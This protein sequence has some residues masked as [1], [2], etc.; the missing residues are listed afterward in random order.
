MV[1][2]V[3]SF[4]EKAKE[5]H[6][7]KYDYSKVNY[8]NSYT[9]VCIICHEKDEN[10][11]EHGEFWQTPANHLQGTGCKK[12]KREKQC[13]T[14]SEIQE[15][16]NEIYG[17]IYTVNKRDKK[18]VYFTCEKHGEQIKKLYPFLQGVGC[19]EC[20]MEKIKEK[21]RDTLDE[22]IEKAKKIHGDKYDYSKVLYDGSKTNVCIICPEHGEFY[23][24]PNSLLSGQG[25]PKCGKKSTAKKLSL[26]KEQFIKKAREIHGW[27]YDYSKVEYINYS[28]EVCIICPEHGEF[29]QTPRKHLSGHECPFCNQSK[30][31]K[32]IKMFLDENNVIYETEKKF[33][34]SNKKRYDFYL[35]NYNIL[36]EC[37]GKQHFEPN[38][39]F[40]GDIGLNT[41]ILRDAEKNENAKING[42]NV[43]YY[44]PFYSELEKEM[45]PKFYNREN[46]FTKSSNLLI[47]LK[48]K[49]E[50]N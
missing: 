34:W 30:L 2:D 10:G 40:G 41:T 22:F 26:T 28:T 8:I 25:C 12:C 3:E 32:N 15:K 5:I 20:S 39:F 44:I 4:I 35:P 19:K 21:T 33:P 29:W 43:I 6:G 18:Y 16:S 1:K 50:R 23:M 48:Q 7:N 36:I 9:N 49:R 46:I 13:L 47:Y 24:M 27:K 14:I 11:N 38:D 37:Q 42:Y 17:N 45:L 31:E